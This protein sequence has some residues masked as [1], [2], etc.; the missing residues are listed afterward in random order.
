MVNE[1]ERP[2]TVMSKK[3]ELED[4]HCRAMVPEAVTFTG[5]FSPPPPNTTAVAPK[6]RIQP[7]TSPPG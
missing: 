7:C 4:T 1:E 6:K 2:L 5:G 3:S